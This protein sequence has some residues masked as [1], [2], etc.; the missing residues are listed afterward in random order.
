ME[1]DPDASR[2]V[3]RIFDMAEVGK[4]TLDI[5][6]TLNNEGIASPRGKLWGKTS[7]HA[8]LINEAYTGTLLWGANPKDKGDPV[9][10]E[11]AFP[12]IIS[13]AQFQRVRKH[14]SS[15]APKTAHPR[16]VGSSFMLSG[17]VKCKTCDRALTGQFS[18]SGQYSYYVCQS[19]IKRGKDACNTPR[20]NARRFEELVV[21]QIRSNVLTEGI[22]RDLVKMVEEEMDRMAHEQRKRLETI[23]S[24]LAEVR[25]GLDRLWDLVETTDDDLANNAARIKAH[26]ERQKR[27]EDAA[28]EV[29]AVLSGRQVKLDEVETISVFAQDTR[30]F[31]N[32][33]E[34]NAQG[35]RRVVRE[36]DR[37]EPRPSQGALHN[38]HAAG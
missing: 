24:E 2:I 14:M 23:E 5:A 25:R 28:R 4:G 18:K 33:S 1:P 22:I 34:L 35:V 7:V 31:L 21:E 19:I 26:R 12:S 20:L 8:I 10:V 36:G 37:G 32:E 16:R 6:R 11:K 17:L 27:L 38:P 30:A 29:E 13:R 3:K 9:R 15:R